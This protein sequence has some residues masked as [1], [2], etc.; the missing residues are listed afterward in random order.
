MTNHKEDNTMGMIADLLRPV[1]L[2]RMLPVRQKFDD[3]HIPDDALRAHILKELD[4]PEFAGRILPGRE[5]AITGGSRGIHAIDIIIKSVVDFVKARGAVPFIVPAM[6]S[7]GG[8]TAEGQREILAGYRITPETMGC[9]IRASMETVQIGM[10]ETGLPVRIDAHAARSDGIILV[11]RVKPHTA[12]RGPYESGMM[13]MMAIG[14][15][16]QYGAEV[17]HAE[18]FHHFRER[19]PMFGSAIL[20]N[21]PVIGGLAIVENAYDR[22]RIVK[23]LT[24]QEIIDEEPALLKKAYA[25]MPRILFDPI[26]VLLVDE[27][28]KEFSGDGMDPNITGRFPVDFCSGGVKCQ[29]LVCLDLTEAS[30]GNACGVGL[31]DVVTRRLYDKIDFETMYPNAITNTMTNVMKI[32]IVMENDRLALKLAVKCLNDV[33]KTRP[34]IVHLKNTGDLEHIEISEA[35]LPLAETMEDI[36]ILGEPREIAFDAE[37][38]MV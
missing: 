21:A 17:I 24:P 9:E 38:N 10:T 29:R 31:A 33:D 5:I 14:L 20:K 16:K 11:G 13:K 37:G 32:P 15:G 8:A 22:P 23:S 4:R 26:E 25:W 6:G 36:E 18:G 1:P 28:G 34:R 2:P 7:H 3:T 35:L 12:F 27:M 30:H 19:I